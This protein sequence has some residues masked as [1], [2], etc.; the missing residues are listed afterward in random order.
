MPEAGFEPACLLGATPS[1]WCVCQFH[2]SGTPA[3]RTPRRRTYF[4]AGLFAGS[5]AFAGGAGAV[6]FSFSLP[7][8][9]AAGAD[10]APEE[11]GAETGAG[12]C[13]NTDPLRREP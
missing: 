7:A 5:A 10:E 9:D 3:R 4:G 11:A 8:A 12:A 2:H 6:A 13:S 1:R